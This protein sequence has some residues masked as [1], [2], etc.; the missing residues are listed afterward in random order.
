MDSFYGGRQGR[1]YNIVARF[2]SIDDMVTHFAQST[3]TD[4]NFGQYVMIDTINEPEGWTGEI[5]TPKWTDRQNGAIYRRGFDITDTIASSSRTIVNPGNGA[6]YVGQIPSGKPGDS[7]ENVQVNSE[8]NQ[9]TYDIIRWNMT[10]SEAST[11]KVASTAG[12]IT[13]LT[14]IEFVTEDFLNP[15]F[16][17]TYSGTHAPQS[18]TNINYPVKIGLKGDNLTVLYANEDYRNSIDNAVVYPNSDL[19]WENLGEVTAQFH[20]YGDYQDGDDGHASGSTLALDKIKYDYPYGLGKNQDGSLVSTSSSHSNKQGWLITVT[21]TFSKPN[22]SETYYN[23]KCYAYD[24]RNP[25]SA[26]ASSAEAQKCWYLMGDFSTQV[27][28]ESMSSRMEPEKIMAIGTTAQ[29]G[30]IASSLNNNGY[31][32]VEE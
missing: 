28:A 18:F 6:I 5:W 8:T 32:F 26:D 30:A 3:Y 29:Q 27:S 19:K 12:T 22:D 16:E 9:I 31:W 2:S 15:S 23:Y 17:T 21:S 7:I 10:P 20:V 4:V 24:Y 1:T 14:N 11:S 25:K 13:A